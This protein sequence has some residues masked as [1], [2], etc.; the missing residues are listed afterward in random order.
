MDVQ[1]LS[2]EAFF[3]PKFRKYRSAAGL[4]PDPL[5]LYSAPQN[6]A[7]LTGPTSSRGVEGW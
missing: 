2:L 3:S 4:R 7:G 6:L 5:T 1:L